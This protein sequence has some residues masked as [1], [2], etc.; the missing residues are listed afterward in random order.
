MLA[1]LLKL[2]HAEDIRPA[3]VVS[4]QQITV[5]GRQGLAQQPGG[6]DGNLADQ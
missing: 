4:Y 2:L 5:T 6:C 3:A 1:A